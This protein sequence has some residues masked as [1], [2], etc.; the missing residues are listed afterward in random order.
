MHIDYYRAYDGSFIAIRSDGNVYKYLTG[1]QGMQG[2]DTLN[3]CRW[4]RLKAI[5]PSLYVL[6]ECPKE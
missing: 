4:E 1:C 2:Y 5:D 3:D 6:P